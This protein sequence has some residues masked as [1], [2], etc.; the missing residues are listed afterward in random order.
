MV[1][2]PVRALLLERGKVTLKLT[3]VAAAIVVLFGFLFPIGLRLV[4]R[5]WLTTFYDA[6]LQVGAVSPAYVLATVGL[7]I[8]GA[9]L[10]LIPIVFDASQPKNWLIPA[11]MLSAYPTAIVV[12]L[13]SSRLEQES[14]SVYARRARALGLPPAYIVIVEVVPN[15]LP[16]ALAALANSLTYF[17]TGSFF[18]ESVFGIPGLGRLTQEALRNKDVNVLA[19]VCYLY[20]FI[21]LFLFVSLD[22]LQSKLDPRTRRT[23]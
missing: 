16:T 1:R 8:G 7:L 21:V 11:A 20:S 14:N 4:R 5:R 13:F 3:A 19:G 22:F 6:I 9:W 23:M 10:G 12:Q 17:V 18:V 15:A 2:R